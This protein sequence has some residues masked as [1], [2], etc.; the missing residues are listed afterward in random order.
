MIATSSVVIVA[1]NEQG[2]RIGQSH[3]NATISDELVDKIRELHEDYGW[4]YKAICSR[5]R[6]SLTAVRKI[7][8][9]ERRAQTPSRWKRVPI[10]TIKREPNGQLSWEWVSRIPVSHC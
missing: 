5:L 7:C 2:L 6:L 10:Y 8:T 4:G 3:H 9:Y 1:Y